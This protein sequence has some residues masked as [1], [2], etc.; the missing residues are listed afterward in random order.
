MKKQKNFSIKNSGY[1]FY[2]TT[3][4]DDEKECYEKI[5]NALL[6]FE[7]KLILPKFYPTHLLRIFT[8]VLLDNPIIFYFDNYSFAEYYIED[9][10]ELTLF[11]T[12]SEKEAQNV[13]QQ[14]LHK[15]EKIICFPVNLSEYEKMLKIHS[16]FI[17]NIRYD[18]STQDP[19]SFN[20]LGPLLSGAGVCMGIS[21]AIKLIFDSIGIDC[22]IVEGLLTNQGSK[23]AHCWNILKI[24]NCFSHYDFTADICLSENLHR[25]DYVGLDDINIASDHKTFIALPSCKDSSYYSITGKTICTKSDFTKALVSFL[26]TGQKSMVVKVDTPV[27]SE[28]LMPQIDKTIQQSIANSSF[29]KYAITYN[30][31]QKVFQINFQ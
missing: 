29:V 25:F 12:M 5:R 2:Y 8:Y 4:N 28:R 11:Y 24:S 10:L 15:I 19:A 6:S 23:E 1:K 17:D 20:I 7:I 14:I 27:T 26:K 13:H 3:L 21:K 22:I 31:S 18:Y 9:K 30:D 16:F